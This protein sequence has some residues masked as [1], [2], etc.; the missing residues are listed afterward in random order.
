MITIEGEAGKD[1]CDN[2][3]KMSRRDILRVGGSGIMGM[4]LANLL[5]L[6]AAQAKGSASNHAR[7]WGKAKSII[8]CYLQGGPSH[9]DLWDPKENAPTNVKSVFDS[10]STSIPGVSFTENLPKLAQVNDKFTTIRSMSYTPNG[11]FN[12]TAAIYQMMTG[13]T[14]DKVSPSGQLEP[15][16]PKDFPNFG[17]N[18]IKMRPVDTPMLPF[19]MLPRP[20]QESNVVGKGGTAG[21]LGK[22]FDPYTLY[23][24][25]DDMD[26]DKMSKIKIDDLKL[27]PE[28]FS[29]RLKRRAQLRE[30]IASGMPTIDKA[31]ESYNLNDYYD[32]AL[33]L[34]VSG[35]AREAFDLDAEPLA[36]HE[37]Y[38]RNT[39]GQSCLL[40]RRLVEAGTR[41]VEVI[42][43]KQA[44]SNNHSWDHHVDLNNR[45]KN[46]SAPMLDA[47]LSGLISDLDERGLLEETLVVAVGEF[48]RSPQKGVSTSGNGNSADGRDH[49][50]YCYTAVV[51][52]A[53]IGR[54]QIY[55][56]SDATA[57]APAENPVHPGELLA[58]IYHA[59][60]IEPE[61]IVYNH[62][63]QPREL[64]KAQAVTG[65]FA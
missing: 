30:A 3:L 40:A 24:E 7:G 60:G 51:A 12:H 5:Q 17:S 42:W 46:Q 2:H 28:V 47:G 11:L 16:S 13:Y 8:L 65:L 53:G 50:P 52:G 1:L 10:I 62:L 9:I 26:M 6:Q 4:S 19:V 55:G 64:V 23:P 20:L 41:V 38:G 43:P 27:R 56:K 18:I 32:Q 45:M 37:K 48:G 33:N 58:T 54:G 29:L 63:N 14:T 39:F 34:I 31:V 57:S 44:N 35:K 22:A 25:G 59:F 61:T 21:F 15:P 36:V 49:W